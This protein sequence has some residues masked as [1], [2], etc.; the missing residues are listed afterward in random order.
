[1]QLSFKTKRLSFSTIKEK[2]IPS[3]FDLHSL[4]EVAQFNTI[5]TPLN[6]TETARLLA[7][8]LDALDQDNL[9]WILHDF[10]DNFI[11][12]MGLI[13]APKRF[14]K[15]EISYSISPS[16]W[17][18][19]YATEAVKKVLHFGFSTLGL[20]RMEAGVAVEN[21]ASIRVLEKAGM[22]RE[23]VHK[24]I[25]PLQS[26]WSDNYSYAILAEE[27]YHI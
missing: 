11:G 4:A 8:K 25:L 15:A 18:K 1:M 3:I 14:Q 6:K 2:D 24:K 26:G 23:G 7:A 17:N 10:S 9:G 22:K 16:F 21:N 20:H 19:G 13:L 5:G 27:F 12:E